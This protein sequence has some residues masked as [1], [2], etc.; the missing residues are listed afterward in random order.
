MDRSLFSKNA[1]GEF[2]PVSGKEPDPKHPG[3]FREFTGLGFCPSP[4]P[5]RLDWERL[6]GRVTPLLIQAERGLARLER[7]AHRLPNPRLLLRPIL[8]REARLSSR[9]ENTVATP[10]E[11]V[12]AGAGRMTSRPEALEVF[13]YVTAIEHGMAS[14]LP[15]CNRLLREMHALLLKWVAAQSKLPG[16]YRNVAVYIG[17]ELEGFENARYVPPPPGQALLQ[18]MGDLERFMNQ[19]EAEHGV[20]DLIAISLIHYQFEAIHPFCDGNGRIGRLLIPL[21]LVRYGVLSQPWVYISEYFER[22]RQ[23][24]YDHLLKISMDGEWEAWIRFCLEGFAVQAEST[25]QRVASITAAWDRMS[26]LV[27]EPRNSVWLLPVI[28]ALFESPIVTVNRVQEIAKVSKTAARNL[29]QK[30]KDYG[31]LE[32]YHTPGKENAY[33]AWEII[34]T[35]DEG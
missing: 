19:L 10:E 21:S 16:D 14:T 35:A 22:N 4:L 27:R 34:R 23:Q 29:I 5:P 17:N 11:I 15:L 6:I 33:I 13:N 12:A 30:L 28:D 25:R 7:E 24:Y 26:H 2:I 18:A 8:N 32:D 3:K 9:I 20:P 1:P 31:I